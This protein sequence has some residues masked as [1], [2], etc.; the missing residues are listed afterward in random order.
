MCWRGS[1]P[2][3]PIGLAHTHQSTKWPTD[4][5]GNHEMPLHPPGPPRGQRGAVIVFLAYFIVIL[6]GF[7]GL[8]VDMGKLMVTRTQLQRAADAAALAGASAINL[9]TGAIDPDTA[10]ARAAETAALNLAFGDGPA[11]VLLQAGD[12]EFPAPLQVKVT[13]RRQIGAGGSIVTYIARVVGVAELELTADATA[14]ADTA[15]RPCD[16]LVPMGPVEPPN[17]GWFDP[18]CAVTYD[19]KIGAGEGEQGNYELLDYPE[20]GEGPCA[21]LEGGAAIR[22]YA[23]YGYGCCLDEGQ[24]FALTEPGNKVGPFRQGMQARFD[25]DTDRREGICYSEYAGNGARVM[26]LPVIETF[27][28]NGKKVVRIIKFS[29]FFMKERPPGNGTLTGQ[30]VHDVTPGEG[31]GQG[32]GTLWVI[33]LIE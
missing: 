15:G 28:V 19:L 1:R 2:P 12:V 14:E 27:D 31:A 21:G 4:R 5:L 25:S 22:C 20:C 33:R 3:L 16:G 29:A 24:E 11:P 6:L 23:Q 17:S 7:L 30:F 26:P 9:E 18:D 32:N 8:A 13:A 10:I